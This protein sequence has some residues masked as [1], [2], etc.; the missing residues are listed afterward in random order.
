M[1]EEIQSLRKR[2]GDVDND[3]VRVSI[4]LNTSCPN[5]D[6]APPPAYTPALLSPLLG[7]LADAF[8]ADH[9]L[10]LGLKLPPYTYSTQ[11]KDVLNTIASLTRDIDGRRHNPIAFLTCTNTLGNSLLF[12]D[13]T[14]PALASVSGEDLNSGSL[15]FALP[16]PLGG[17]AGESIHALALGNVHTF[18]KLLSKSED[19]ALQDIAIIGVGG[20]RSP[21]AVSRMRRAGAVVVGCATYLGQ[22]GVRAFELLSA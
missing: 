14:T 15:D 5:I 12:A 9:T 21:A 17:L 1:I 19:N 11:F 22:E 4:E 3:R 2:L 7:V 8:W 20:V 13:Q 6:N 16:A 10:V 18:S